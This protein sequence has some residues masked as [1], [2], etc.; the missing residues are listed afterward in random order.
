MYVLADLEW[1]SP[2]KAMPYPTQLALVRVDGDWGPLSALYVRCRPLEATPDWSFCAFAGGTPE[3]FLA[4]PLPAEAERQAGEWLREDDILCWWFGQSGRMLQ[5]LFPSLGD[6]RSVELAPYMPEHLQRTSWRRKN[7]YAL[8]RELFSAA[9]GEPPEGDSLSLPSPEHHAHN[10]A[11]VMRLV[12]LRSRFPQPRLLEPPADREPSQKRRATE[13]RESEEKPFLYD[14]AQN[15]IHQRDCSLIEGARDLLPFP[16]LKIP[17]KRDYRPCPVCCAPLY[18]QARMEKNAHSLKKS[19]YTY[20]YAPD[21]DVFHRYTCRSILSARRIL[22]TGKYSAC[23]ESGRRPCKLCRPTPSDQPNPAAHAAAPSPGSAAGQRKKRDTLSWEKRRAVIRLR[24]AQ[25]ERF[26]SR[27]REA[28]TDVDR[29]DFFTLTQPRFAFWA[30]KGYQNFHTR[31][32]PKL[33]EL[34]SLTGFARFNDAIRAGFTPCKHCKPSKRQDVV[35]SIPISSRKRSGESPELLCKLCQQH[36]YPC[37]LDQA[38]GVFQMETPVGKW[39]VHLS[40][41]PITLEHINL[42]S[43]R[44]SRTRYHR[45]PRMFLSL[46]DTFAYIHRHDSALLKRQSEADP[47]AQE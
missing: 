41:D 20:V 40:A 31:N 12:L 29:E 35:Y 13:A 16:S 38:G 24:Q 17:L 5:K 8:A 27:N 15:T 32:C 44:G 19:Q 25:R 7:L 2:A 3:D 34:S 46:A 26:S 1:V 39:R 47:A 42:V 22:G 28:L 43:P 11:E 4:A 23:V 45:Q 18:R 14:P 33:Q 6:R 10:D 9:P 37:S 21:S 36:G 30:A